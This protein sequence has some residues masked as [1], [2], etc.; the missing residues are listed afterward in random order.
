LAFFSSFLIPNTAVFL[1]TES[2]ERHGM[3][4]RTNLIPKRLSILP[5]SP[6]LPLKERG[7][8]KQQ[9]KFIIQVSWEKLFFSLSYG[10][11]NVVNIARNYH[12]FFSP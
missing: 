2:T 6:I 10:T 5:F 8:P 12:A 3:D 4:K 11:T 9:K 7:L 1:A